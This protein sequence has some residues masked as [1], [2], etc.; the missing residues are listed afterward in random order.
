MDEIIRSKEKDLYQD[1]LKQAALYFAFM[2]LMSL[3]VFLW[4]K[5]QAHKIQSGIR[6][7][8]NFFETASSQAMA[9][10]PT[11][12]QFEELKRIAKA[13]NQ[14]IDARTDA[15]QKLGESEKR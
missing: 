13:A 15:F 5:Y 12:L 10:D 2:I 4:I 6:L 7:F 11:D 3:L 1:F 14:M 9:I 8:T